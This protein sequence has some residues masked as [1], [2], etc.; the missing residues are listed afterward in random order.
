MTKPFS[1]TFHCNNC[2]TWQTQET[3]FGRWLR[4]NKSFSSR[5][6]YAITDIDWLV[7]EFKTIHKFNTGYG[8]DFQLMMEIEVKT[9]GADL[10]P[11][12]RDTLAI[13][14]ALVRNR[15]Q[16][17]TKDLKFQAGNSIKVTSVINGRTVMVRH[18][19]VHSL[20]FSGLGPNDSEWIMWDKQQITVE[21][22][23][24]LIR[25]DLDPDTLRPIDLRNHHVVRPQIIE[26][27]PFDDEET[28]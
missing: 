1:A 23:T 10:S 19:G 4:N 6:G 13:R 26:S 20:R 24:S 15:K 21:Q 11:S 28:A 18:Y 8:R 3:E 2:K 25:F 7:T 27:L 22:L 9:M 17:P 5:D 14:N 16:T 12:Q